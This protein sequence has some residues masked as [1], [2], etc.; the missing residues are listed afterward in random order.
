M[1][2]FFPKLFFTIFNL[3]SMRTLVLC[4][5][6]FLEG[7]TLSGQEIGKP[8]FIKGIYGNPGTLLQAGHTFQSLGVNA[9]FV[10]SVSLTADLYQ[11]ARESGVK[12]F[13]EFPLL[14]GKQY[15]EEHPEAWPLNEKGEKAPPADW[16]MGVCPTDAGFRSYRFDQ[17][18]AIL[19]EYEV[20]GIW[21]DYVHWHAQFE[22]A[23]PILPE[24]CFCQRCIN[25]FG[26][27]MSIKVPEGEIAQRSSWILAEAD[28]LWRVWRSNVL[29]GWVSEMKTVVKE[30]RPNALVGIFYCS[31]FPSD[32]GE[33]L[34]RTLGLNLNE[35]AGVVDV[36]SPMLFHGMMDR[37]VG[38]VHEYVEWLSTLPGSTGNMPVIWPIV[39]AHNK[40]GVIT[41]D[42]F[43]EVLQN[44]SRPPASGIMMFSDQSLLQ[45]PEK[46]KVVKE[47]YG[48]K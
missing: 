29:T 46:L 42:E 13:V 22:T 26:R 17:V 44:G 43:Y 10:R 6:L 24:T 5:L 2:S 15:V 1:H 9:I 48:K 33:A 35:L 31:W 23:E 8:S 27:E 12:V 3:R 25:T 20:D 16:F 34:Y 40:P 21:L 4:F 37:P 28:S 14:N 30:N 39:Q 36:F 19:K 18:H 11:K 47:F 32:F 38:W 45:D 7:L 41:A